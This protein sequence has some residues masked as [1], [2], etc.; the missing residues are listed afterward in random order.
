ML[1][2]P[3]AFKKLK[4]IAEEVNTF[5]PTSMPAPV[6]VAGGAAAHYGKAGDID[7]WFGSGH[8]NHAEQFLKKLPYYQA[9]DNEIAKAYDESTGALLLGDGYDPE[10]GKIIQVLVVTDGDPFQAMSKFDISTHRWAYGLVGTNGICMGDDYT[11][12]TDP[13]KILKWNPKTFSRYVKIC[14]RYGHP[15]DTSQFEQY[16][17]AEHAQL[18]LPIKPSDSLKSTMNKMMGLNKISKYPQK[19]YSNVSKAPKLYVP[20]EPKDLNELYN[21]KVDTHSLNYDGAIHDEV[22]I[23]PIIIDDDIKF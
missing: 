16:M 3:E 6:W 22:L 15:V 4:G 10:I 2:M 19:Q 13:P 9:V 8:V 18:T 11:Y 7:V 12:C 1:S 14:N 23:T 20:N 21:Q 5:N 17:K